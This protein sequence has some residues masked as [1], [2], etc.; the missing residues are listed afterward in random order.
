MIF[1]FQLTLSHRT[2]LLIGDTSN[3]MHFLQKICVHFTMDNV[4][5]F[6]LS[7]SRSLLFYVLGSLMVFSG[8][9]KCRDC[10][11][12]GIS[13]RYS[14]LWLTYFPVAK[15]SK[16]QWDKDRTMDTTMEIFVVH[17]QLLLL[18]TENQYEPQK[19]HSCSLRWLAL[20][21]KQ[22]VSWRNRFVC[23]SLHVLCHGHMQLCSIH[24]SPASYD[25]ASFMH[26]VLLRVIVSEPKH[27]VT[28]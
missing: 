8:P 7:S 5:Q 15:M 9:W 26:V 28:E 10:K 3:I 16:A 21:Y 19:Q 18:Y 4:L 1:R 11:L 22:S 17:R 25:G 13:S 6:C 24:N 12:V 23:S 2:D 20:S 27:W 14:S